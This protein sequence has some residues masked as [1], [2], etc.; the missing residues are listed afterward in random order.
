M[1]E[2]NLIDW[3]RNQP[4]DLPSSLIKGIG[5]D[6][7][8]LDPGF[9]R[10]MVVTTDVLV[11]DVH[12][13]RRWINPYFLG[14]KAMAVNLS[15][16]A[17]M[18][19]RPYG[20]LLGLAL[21]S[22]LTRGYFPEFMRG[23]LEEGGRWKA[24][25]IGGD[26]SRGRQIQISV[27]MLGYV[28][29]GDPIYRSTARPEDLILVIGE[30]GFSGTGLELL[31][32]EDPEQLSIAASERELQDWAGDSFR[33]RCLKAHLLPQPQLD[34]AVWL[35][36]NGLANALID[37]SDGLAADLL[38]IS[39]QSRLS[40]QLQT[41][42]LALSAGDA[43]DKIDTKM[44]LEGGEDYALLF[45][46][47]PEQ[48]KRLQSLYPGDLPLCH[49]IG[50]LVKGKPGLYLTGPESREE[51]VPRGFDHFHSLLT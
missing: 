26:L 27:T 25:L 22:D 36:E 50:K 28:G 15:D 1:S 5:D 30:L 43:G 45:T 6:C 14:R 8:V 33:Y 38:H 42:R 13:R 21:P 3:V 24:P 23:F 2:F 49:I 29:N 35:Q 19:A 37:V 48:V 46:A 31:E 10:R 11:E 17:A 40:A 41:E 4:Q 7:A 39:R 51:Y 18:G 34:A 32:Q 16:L 47:S 9:A 12:F 20:C 44:I